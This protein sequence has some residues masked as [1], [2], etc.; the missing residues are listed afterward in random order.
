MISCFFVLASWVAVWVA[1]LITVN[2]EL[3]FVVKDNYSYIPR[4]HIWKPQ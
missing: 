2:S 4:Y 3:G 1:N